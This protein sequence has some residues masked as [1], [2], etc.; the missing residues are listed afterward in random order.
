LLCSDL[1]HAYR[2]H[3]HHHRHNTFSSLIKPT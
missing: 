2:H 3:N 1:L